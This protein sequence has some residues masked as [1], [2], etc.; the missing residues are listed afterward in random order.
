MAAG[1]QRICKSDEGINK[2]LKGTHAGKRGDFWAAGRSEEKL[3]GQR[4]GRAESG[5]CRGQKKK[6]YLKENGL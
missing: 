3:M 1:E 4:R 6:I 2:R 5:R